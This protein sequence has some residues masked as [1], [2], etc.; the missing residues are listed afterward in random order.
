MMPKQREKGENCQRTLTKSDLVLTETVETEYKIELN[1]AREM[2]IR[3]RK[4]IE[5]ERSRHGETS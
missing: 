5:R 4:E 2:V 3:D 1:A